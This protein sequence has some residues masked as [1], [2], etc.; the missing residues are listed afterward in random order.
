LHVGCGNSQLQDRLYEKGYH[1]IINIDI[2]SVVIE[3][4]NKN[5]EL[6][7]Y[8]EMVFEVMDVRKM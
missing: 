2:S 8:G 3:Q 4:M 6:N 7:N 1:K 5:K